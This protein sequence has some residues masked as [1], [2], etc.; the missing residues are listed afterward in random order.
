MERK[1]KD[2]IKENLST[3]IITSIVTL[4]PMYIGLILWNRLP[5][6]IAVHFDASGIPDNYGSKVFT[7]FGLALI[8]FAVHV[9][10]FIIITMC[11]NQSNGIPDR[12]LR[13][14]L[15]I[16]PAVSIFVSIIIYGV[17][18]GMNINVVFYSQIFLG[19]VFMLFGNYMPKVRQNGFMGIRVIWTLKSRRN[20]EHTQR[21]GGFVLC[22]CGLL[23]LINALTGITERFEDYWF[24]IVFIGIILFMF[25]STVLYSFLYFMKHEKEPNYYE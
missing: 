12:F 1:W 17:A 3:V 11:K 23:F 2:R 8:I 7:V 15:W 10:C 16:C 5:N 6:Q 18:L 9:S 21:F 4:L 20:W 25:L 14:L 13:L 24:P 22:L 19:I